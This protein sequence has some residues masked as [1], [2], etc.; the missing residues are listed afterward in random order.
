M[1]GYFLG[2]NM[3]KYTQKY[4][5]VGG[6]SQVFKNVSSD[7]YYMYLYTRSKTRRV[8]GAGTHTRPHTGSHTT[9]K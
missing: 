7:Y 5:Q 3:V 6:E 8:F 1:L 9:I 2:E 4:M